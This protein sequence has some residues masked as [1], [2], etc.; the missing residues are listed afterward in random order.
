MQM[1]KL[2]SSEAGVEDRQERVCLSFTELGESLESP[3]RCDGLTSSG[4]GPPVGH[5]TVDVLQHPMHHLPRRSAT[6]THRD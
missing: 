2:I 3:Q 1:E 5:I 6:F 4:L